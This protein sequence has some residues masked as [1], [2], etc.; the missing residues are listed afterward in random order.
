VATVQP[1]NNCIQPMLTSEENISKLILM[2]GLKKLGQSSQFACCHVGD[3]GER[4]Q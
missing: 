4:G 3:Q 2:S 1:G